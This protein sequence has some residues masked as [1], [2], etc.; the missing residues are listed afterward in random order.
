MC[1]LTPH[2]FLAGRAGDREMDPRQWLQA[3]K[4]LSMEWVRKSLGG[5][6]AEAWMCQAVKPL[7]IEADG[8]QMQE[9]EDSWEAQV[10][11]GTE[12]L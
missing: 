10:Q 2:G 9:W 11:F 5:A 3:F 8:K 6:G 4:P 1:P 7:L 12:Q